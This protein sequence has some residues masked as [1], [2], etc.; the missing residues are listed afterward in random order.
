KFIVSYSE[1]LTEMG[2]YLSSVADEIYLNP[3]GA[4][5][6]NGLSSEMVFMK[7]LFEKIEVQPVI[8]REGEFKSAVEAFTL[9][10]MSEENRLQTE[11]YHQDLNDDS[12]RHITKSLSIDFEQLKEIN[13]QMLVKDRK[14]V[15]K[16]GVNDGLWY[17]DQ[18][19]DLFRVK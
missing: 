13:D 3:L 19:K 16:L 1:V 8:F 4:I 9:D 14:D 10:K 12:L 6:F 17:D 2:Y 5:E 15:V 11:A 7:G 18:V